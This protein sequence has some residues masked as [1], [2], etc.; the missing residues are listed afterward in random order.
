MEQFYLPIGV[1]PC[2]VAPADRNTRLANQYRTDSDS[3]R[4]LNPEGYLDAVIDMLEYLPPQ[5]KI[6]RLGSEVPPTVLVSPDWGL[7]LHKFPALFEAR[8]QARN[9]WQGRLFADRIG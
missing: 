7:R 2:A 5:I 1:S 9:T 8:L 4:L 6:Q 3:I